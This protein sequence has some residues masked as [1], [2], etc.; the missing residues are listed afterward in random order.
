MK[1]LKAG[2]QIVTFAN[3]LIDSESQLQ[4]ALGSFV[5]PPPGAGAASTTNASQG[6][7]E[8][9]SDP[10]TPR[11]GSNV[12]RVKLTDASGAPVSGAE[13]SVTFFM[14]AMPALGM[15]AMRTPLTLSDK[16]N[17]LHKGAG[18]FGTSGEWPIWTIAQTKGQTIYLDHL[19]TTTPAA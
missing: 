1:G 12:F 17:R 3:F 5:P 15:A 9:S 13:A 19:H 7:V 10:T 11:K 6:I 2:E 18:E 14:P 16:G 8:L 4:A